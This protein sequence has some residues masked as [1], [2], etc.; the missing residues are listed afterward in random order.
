MDRKR[1]VAAAV[2]ALMLSL[3]IGVAFAAPMLF[4]EARRYDFAATLGAIGQTNSEITAVNADILVS[5]QD[6]QQ[7]TE[8]VERVRERLGRL[9]GLLGEQQAAL[10]RLDRIT[11]EQAG[12]SRD[13][14]GLTV[15]AAEAAGA[16]AATAATQAKAVQRMN[17]QTAALA[18]RLE[19]IGSLNRDGARKLGRAEELSGVVLDRMP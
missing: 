16:M 9:E 6:V 12:L 4:S 15:G 3:L 1:L 2:G 17:E 10:D 13:L 8:G 19:S 7:Q 11:A 5:L 14:R 18:R